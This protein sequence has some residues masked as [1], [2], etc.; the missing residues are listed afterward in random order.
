[1]ASSFL[2]LAFGLGLAYALGAT[3]GGVLFLRAA[4]RL[5]ADPSRAAAMKSF[6]ASLAQLSLLLIGVIADA[7]WRG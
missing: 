6:H 4:A 2:P 5:A 1:V 7:A 3:A